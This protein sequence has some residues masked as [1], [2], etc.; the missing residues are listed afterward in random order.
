MPDYHALT[1]QTERR[2]K[3]D[4]DRLYEEPTSQAQEPKHHSRIP[5][6]KRG[7][8]TDYN[9]LYEEPT[10]TERRQERSPPDDDRDR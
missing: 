10:D 9:R 4:Y 6:R 8:Q 2:R 3:A 1:E 5:S 7:R